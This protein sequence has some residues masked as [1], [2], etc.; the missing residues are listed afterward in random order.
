MTYWRL[1]YHS[2]WATK[3]RMQWIAPGWETDLH[4][5]IAAKAQALG[6]LVYAVGGIE[7]H[8]HLV[9]SIPPKHS[10]ASFIG[11]IKGHSAHFINHAPKINLEAHFNWQRGY[12]IVSFG[13]K[14]LPKVTNYVNQQREHHEID[15][16]IPFLERSV[17]SQL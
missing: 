2:T 16:V 9:V 15:I 4:S 14:Q 17:H 5:V 3:N 1:F 11:Q 8:V 10:L 7:D 12:G 13:E 6:G